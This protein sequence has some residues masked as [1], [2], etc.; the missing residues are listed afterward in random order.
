RM[1][2]ESEEP[3]GRIA[4]RAGFADQSHF[5]RVFRSSRGTTPGALRR[6]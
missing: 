3:I 2:R 4:I 1:I 5:T 6:E